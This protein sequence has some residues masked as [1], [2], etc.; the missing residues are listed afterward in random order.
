MKKNK[1]REN[2]AICGCIL[3]R[4]GEYAKPTLKGR[5]HATKHHFVAER[6]FGRTTNRKGEKREGIFDICPWDAENKTVVF[7]YECHEELLH[8]PI[9]LPSDINNLA[10]LVRIRGLNE[11]EKTED[12]KNIAGRIEL[13][14]EIIS[15]GLSGL[16]SEEK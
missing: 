4:D 5:S 16:L 11:E 9:F 15:K 2:C 7:C 14:Q 12:R 1:I 13:L 3:H 6:F 8:N 10:E